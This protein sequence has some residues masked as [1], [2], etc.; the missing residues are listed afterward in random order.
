MKIA[1]DFDGTIVENAYPHIGRPMS[2][3]FETIHALQQ[4]GHDIVLWTYRDGVQLQ[5]AINFCASKGI[6]FFSI[7][8]SR[9]DEHIEY[10]HYFDKI[11]RKIDAD[12]FIDDRNVGGFLGWAKVWEL[13][14]PESGDLDLGF[15]DEKAHFN[16]NK[17]NKSIFAKIFGK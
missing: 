11:S 12:I 5:E 3:A 13:L 7:N 9:P 4:K 8:H 14:H 1:I 6:T 2:K 15:V 17:E 10:P 16:K